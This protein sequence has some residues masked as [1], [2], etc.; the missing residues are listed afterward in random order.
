MIIDNVHQNGGTPKE[1]QKRLPDIKQY[2]VVGLRHECDYSILHNRDIAAP[3]WGTLVFPQLVEERYLKISQ[4][5]SIS[6]FCVIV[7]F[8]FPDLET[9]TFPAYWENNRI[10]TF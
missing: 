1:S 3:N 10:H 8:T 7:I 6:Q 9:L 5:V 4:K 2:S